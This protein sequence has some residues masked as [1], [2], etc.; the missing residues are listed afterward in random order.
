M[1]QITTIIILFISIQFSYAQ[2][3]KGKG[4]AYFKVSGWYLEADEHYTNN[5]EIDPNAT[6]SVFF[7]NLYGEYGITD[8]LDGIAFF[9]ALARITQNDQISGTT[10]STIQEGEAINSIGDLDVGIRYGIIPKGKYVLSASLM[11]GIPTG[12]DNGGSDGSFQ[13]GDGEFKQVM[14]NLINYLNL[15]LVVLSLYLKNQLTLKLI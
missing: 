14:E 7:T 5:G 1:K 3:T 4:N 10:N 9:P 6:R 12:N 8:R 2:W 11:L 15:I 13:T